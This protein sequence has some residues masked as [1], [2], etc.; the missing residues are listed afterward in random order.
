MGWGGESSQTEQVLPTELFHPEALEAICEEYGRPYIEL[1]TTRANMRLAVGF[2]CL[3]ALLGRPECLCLPSAGPAKTGSVGSNTLSEPFC[4]PRSSISAVK[5]LIHRCCGSSSV[6]VSQ[7]CE[8]LRP[9]VWKLSE[10]SSAGHIFLRRL[11]GWW[12]PTSG[13]PQHV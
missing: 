5:S 2:I 9:L 3:P 7:D 13:G 1:F 10:H 12:L 8:L 4:D 11:E 6:R